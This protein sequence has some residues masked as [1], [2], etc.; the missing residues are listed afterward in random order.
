MKNLLN[1]YNFTHN[2]EDLEF[3]LTKKSAKAKHELWKKQY[4]HFDLKTYKLINR[5]IEEFIGKSVNDAF[6]KY[7]KLVENNKRRDDKFWNFF[8]NHTYRKSYIKKYYYYDENYII[9]YNNPKSKKP[10]VWKSFDYKE[11]YRHK[12]HTSLRLEDYRYKFYNGKTAYIKQIK[13]WVCE[14]DFI[15][16]IISGEKLEFDSKKDPKYRRLLSEKIKLQNLNQ[17]YRRNFEKQKQYNW[18]SRSETEELNNA[19]KNYVVDD[20][21]ILPKHYKKD[22]N[23]SNYG[24]KGIILPEGYNNKLCCVGNK[25][26]T[27]VLPEGFNSVLEAYDVNEIVFPFGYCNI[28]LRCNPSM[29]LI[30]RHMRKYHLDY[31]EAGFEINDKLDLGNLPH[32]M[33]YIRNKRID[34]ILEDDED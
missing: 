14:K 8:Y 15:P 6:S 27:L 21:L 13:R 23:C 5:I 22:I 7:C 9:R 16:H 12:I 10:I 17:R 11:E 3:S 2:F 29:S 33:T 31:Y 1:K 26:N 34:M 4:Y 18:L 20:V 19:W 25:F 32:L 30:N 24:L 28:G